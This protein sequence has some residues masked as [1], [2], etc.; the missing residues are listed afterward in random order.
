MKHI[1]SLFAL[2]T[3]AVS[4]ACTQAA[5]GPASFSGR[6]VETTNG[7]SYTF[8]L[9]DTGTNKVWAATT[10]FEVKP[11]DHVAANDSMPMENFHSKALNR[12]FPMI[13]FADRL[14]VNGAAPGAAKLP[15]G[16]PAIGGGAGGELPA[17]HPKRTDRPAPVKVDFAGLK[18]AKDGKTVAEIY[19]ASAKLEGKSVTIRGK[20]VKF[21]ANIMGKNW[22]HLRDGTGSAGSDDLLVTTADKAKYGDTVL[23]VGKVARNQDFGAG[24][25]FDVLLEE[26][27][28]TVE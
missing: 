15:P 20:V 2:V 6:V 1:V 9:V 13:Y 17:G 18:P 25:K 19:A 28:V 10:Q 22:L 21:N 26:G 23:V 7:G 27:K 8:L 24:Y 14:A 16:H 4:L 11:G 12:N 3:V 5:A